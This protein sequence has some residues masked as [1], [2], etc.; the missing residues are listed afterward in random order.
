VRAL[1]RLLAPDGA[2]RAELA[3]AGFASPVD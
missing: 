1:V 2:L 3:A